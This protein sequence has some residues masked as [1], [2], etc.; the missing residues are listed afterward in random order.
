MGKLNL[1]TNF[2]NIKVCY[3][4]NMGHYKDRICL[5]K[6]THLFFNPGLLCAGIRY[7]T[8]LENI[9]KERKRRVELNKQSK[10]V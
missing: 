9:K 3:E 8:T 1:P 2:R 6:I 7:I 5:K 10:I 4:S